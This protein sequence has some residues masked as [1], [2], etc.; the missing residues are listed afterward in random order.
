[1]NTEKNDEVIE[2]IFEHVQT[3]FLGINPL[4]DTEKPPLVFLED[5]QR[6]LENILLEYDKVKDDNGTVEMLE[7]AEAKITLP[8]S[9]SALIR[10]TPIPQQGPSVTPEKGSDEEEEVPSR[11][12]LKRQAQIVIDAKSRR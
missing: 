10:K 12:Y 1:E 5:F 4:V 11:G 2:L 3:I 9:Y 6:E 8:P 7:M